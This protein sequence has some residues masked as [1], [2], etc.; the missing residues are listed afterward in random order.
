MQRG[1]IYH[2]I[3][4]MK[5]ELM[6]SKIKAYDKDAYGWLVDNMYNPNISLYPDWN[7]DLSL[8]WGSTPQGR[9]YWHAINEN[10]M[11]ERGDF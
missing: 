11:W 10:V 1:G 9:N 8:G 7:I 5:F 2:P 6:L 4:L 3:K